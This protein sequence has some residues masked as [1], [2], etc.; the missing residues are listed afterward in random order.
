[1]LEEHE[2]HSQALKLSPTELFLRRS[3]RHLVALLVL[4]LVR[5]VF[6][7]EDWRTHVSA[8]NASAS[9]PDYSS[10]PEVRGGLTPYLQLRSSTEAS[11]FYQLAFGASEVFRVPTDAQGRTMH[12]HLYINGS[13]LMLSDAYPEYGHPLQA[14]QAFNLTLQVNDIDAWCAQSQRESK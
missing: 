5:T 9:A 11:A 3:C 7:V 4:A 14:P 13:S 10:M 8:T 1:M 2:R 6:L 12:I